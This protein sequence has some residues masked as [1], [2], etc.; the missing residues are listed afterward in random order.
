MIGVLTSDLIT[1]VKLMIKYCSW[2]R[3][4][5]PCHSAY[6]QFN[7]KSKRDFAASAARKNPRILKVLTS[8]YKYGKFQQHTAY[9]ML[10]YFYDE[11]DERR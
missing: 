8:E 1:T 6:K 10:V 3:D 9:T 11:K 5:G 7:K 2:D 4:L